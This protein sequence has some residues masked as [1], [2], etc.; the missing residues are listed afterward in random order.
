MYNPTNIYAQTSQK[1]TK[2]NLC[3]GGKF[4]ILNTTEEVLWIQASA[5]SQQN[6]QQNGVKT[7][8]SIAISIA[9]QWLAWHMEP[10]S[11]MKITIL[12]AFLKSGELSSNQ[13]LTA[14]AFTLRKF[15]LQTSKT[16]IFLGDS[17]RS[18]TIWVR[19]T[20]L[21]IADM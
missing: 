3:V 8:F 5:I 14:R 1:N 21:D 4:Q 9:F 2:K 16:Q 10:Q 7:R 19:G 15:T 13:V 17:A 20:R 18:E 12:D 6:R 11:V